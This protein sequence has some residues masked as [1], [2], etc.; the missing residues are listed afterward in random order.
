MLIAKPPYKERKMNK[1][2]KIKFQARQKAQ[3]PSDIIAQVHALYEKSSTK[4]AITLT[5][6]YAKIY[7]ANPQILVALAAL[8]ISY[9]QKEYATTLLSK[10]L[11]KDPENVRGLYN[12]GLLFLK[13]GNLKQ[14]EKLFSKAVI[15]D[16][17]YTSAVQNLLY[18]LVQTENV[19]AVNDWFQ[20]LTSDTS[21]SQ[22]ILL[23]FVK[24]FKALNADTHFADASEQFYNLYPNSYE[25][26]FN[27]ALAMQRI[28]EKEIAKRHYKEALLLKPG[29]LEASNNLAKLFFDEGDIRS[30]INL[31]DNTSLE[32]AEKPAILHNMGVALY[33][34]SELERAKKY[35]LK[36]AELAPEMGDPHYTLG[37]ISKDKSEYED[38]HRHFDK[39]IHLC[40]RNTSMYTDSVAQKWLL[41]RYSL[42]W[43]VS[44][45]LEDKIHDLG[46]KTA[47]IAPFTALPM[48]DNPKNQLLRAEKFTNNTYTNKQVHKNFAHYRNSEIINIA[49]ISADFHQFP[50]M[51]LM[52]GMFAAHD[53]RKFKVFALSYGPDRNDPMRQKIVR[54]VDKFIDV[55]DFTD[56]EI[57]ALC[58]NL[59][60]H[61]A[62]HRN[63]YTKL[64]RTGIFAKRAAPI[65]INYLGYPSTM[66]ANFMDYLVADKFVIPEKYRNCYTEKIIYMPNCYQPNDALREW[67][68]D[69]L[70]KIDHGLD[71]QKITLCCFNNPYKISRREFEIWMK[72]LSKRP[73]TQLWL[74]DPG[75]R[76][77]K[78][79]L[80]SASIFEIDK[81]RIVFAPKT[82]HSSHLA[83]HIHADV[84]LDTFNYNA[85]TTATDALG[86][87]VPIITL[88]GQQ[89]S[90]RV[91][92][93][94]LRSA[95]LA[96][97]ITTS[98]ADYTKLIFDLID[99]ETKLDELKSHCG[100][101][102]RNNVLFDTCHYT[103]NFEKGLTGAFEQFKNGSL[104]NDV[105]I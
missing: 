72:V 35:L 53:R 69:K 91:A 54:D 5:K 29:D 31:L 87:G 95:G 47:H 94:I 97:L 59:N 27:F 82:D 70:K 11:A 67:P 41:A 73:N 76:G 10:V 7:H 12:R 65:Q 4:K 1:P 64:H 17:N 58:S 90:A 26:N 75:S 61:I 105:E 89:F 37:L 36:S 57:V 100:S 84:F 18:I 74:L 9:E 32:D 25:S 14:A 42:D 104:T 21:P 79:F 6:K 39:A 88:E 22:G 63:G 46:I 2:S 56:D 24:S 96:E 51:T 83:R 20:K 68:V 43:R 60:I 44:D 16:H 55:K 98:E 99:N 40:D 71:E 93:S 33:A 52:S 103:R 92:G 34:V 86:M 49:Y 78:N 77:K 102:K 30:A 48:E 13:D 3:S 101:L 85:H 28:G 38:A 15:L 19:K 45:P 62:I 23:L 66:G 81:N 8:C 50:G 80:Q